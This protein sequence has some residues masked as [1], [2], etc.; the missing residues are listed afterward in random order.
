MKY[1][2]GDIL[3]VKLS[4]E[5]KPLLV[6]VTRINGSYYRLEFIKD[7]PKG[8][9]FVSRHYIEDANNLIDVNLTPLERILYNVE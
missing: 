5:I 4:Y 3:Y 6:R 1:K 7:Y 9:S 8:L 2:P